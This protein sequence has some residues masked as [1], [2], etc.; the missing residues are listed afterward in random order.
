MATTT[1]T[2]KKTSSSTKPKKKTMTVAQYRAENE[3]L[4]EQLDKIKGGVRCWICGKWKDSTHFYI[5]TDPMIKNHA[6]PNGASVTCCCAQCAK[7][8]ACRKD[9]NGEYHE[10]TK[11]SVMKA[12][13]YLNK[14]FIENVWNASIAESENMIMGNSK[15][16]VWAAYIKNI[17]S[18]KQY[19]GMTFDDSDM[20]KEHIKYDNE[21]SE[22][23]LVEEHAGQDTYDDFVKNKNDVKR[24]LGYDPFEEE[25]ISDQP[26]LYAQLLGLLDQDEGQN[27]DYM[28]VSSCIS[29]T[30]NFLQI[31]KLDDAITK[32]MAF[33]SD[34]VSNNSASIKS[35]Q[36]SKQKISSMITNLAAESC[37]SLK[38]SKHA[39]KGE[40]SFTGK[41]K[42]IK[43][44]NLRDGEINGFTIG[45]CKGMQQVADI[46]MS[47]IIDKLNMDDSEWADI[48]GT[49]R[50]ELSKANKK[51]DSYEEAF[52][53]LLRENLDL[54]KTMEDKNEL[55]ESSLLNLDQVLSIVQEEDKE[56]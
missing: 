13:K 31:Q 50:K 36:D 45:Q 28:R 48:V 39:K 8:I 24:L 14:P 4:K 32:L 1:V 56:K 44:L 42:K 7:D 38:N 49:Q 54:R 53:M 26:F 55:D 11:K 25:K 5:D 46:S 22:K 21:K 6:R 29:I 23:Q 20:F 40:N 27:D 17:S 2:K 9:K 12:L 10:P 18:L 41:L 51:A 34:D 33:G 35:L 47:A 37:I 52:R 15:S 16:N 19:A 30:R 43:D 3:K